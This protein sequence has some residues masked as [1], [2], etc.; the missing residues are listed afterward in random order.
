MI[1]F[2]IKNSINPTLVKGALISIENELF[3]VDDMDNE[4]I[5]ISNK[6]SGQRKISDSDWNPVKLDDDWLRKSN[7]SVGA[8][9]YNIKTQEDWII[10]STGNHYY[11]TIYSELPYGENPVIGIKYVHDLQAWFYRLTKQDLSYI[12]I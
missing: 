7:L 5:A 6:K 8:K 10:K 3:Q 9:I 4:S 12:G 2:D 1:N 11:L